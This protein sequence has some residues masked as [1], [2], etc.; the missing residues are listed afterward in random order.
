MTAKKASS[1]FPIHA[2][3]VE[4]HLNVILGIAQRI[5]LLGKFPLE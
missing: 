4:R 2:P 3:V 5:D 1:D